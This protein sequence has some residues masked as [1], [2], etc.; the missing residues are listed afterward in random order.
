[1]E[2]LTKVAELT[3]SYKPIQGNLPLV[4]SSFDAYTVLKDFFP[5]EQIGMQE[6]FVVMY[7]NNAVKVIGVYRLSVGGITGTVADPRLIL[8]TAL[9]VA[10]TTIIVAHNHPSGNM[11]PS[12][13]DVNLTKKIREAGSFLDIKLTDH[14]IL[15]PIIGNYYSFMDEGMM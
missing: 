15:S 5:E 7:L 4:K 2:K 8:G 9:K 1:M 12:N 14:I 3:V 13:A 6:M 10:A 11:I